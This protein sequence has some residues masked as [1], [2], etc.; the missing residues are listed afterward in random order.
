MRQNIPMAKFLQP[1]TPHLLGAWSLR[2]AWW[3]RNVCASC[4]RPIFRQIYLI[5]NRSNRKYLTCAQKMT[6]ILFVVRTKLKGMT[7]KNLKENR[8]SA[9]RRRHSASH[10][11]VHLTARLMCIHAALCNCRCLVIFLFSRLQSLR[12]ERICKVSII[13]SY[14]WWLRSNLGYRTICSS[15]IVYFLPVLF[16]TWWSWSLTVWY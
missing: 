7:E 9:A 6:L 13:S 2:H 1:I 16:E 12:T 15:V 11:S 3:L 5:I 10:C 4:L 8:C 14:L